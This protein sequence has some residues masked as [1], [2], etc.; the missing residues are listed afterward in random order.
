LATVDDALNLA[1]LAGFRARMEDKPRPGGG[2]K[3]Q[4]WDR[5]DALI[6]ASAAVSSGGYGPPATG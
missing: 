1:W 2:Q 4:G 6:K 3:G 5:A